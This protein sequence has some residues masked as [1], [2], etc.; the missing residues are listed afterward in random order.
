MGQKSEQDAMRQVSIKK[1]N[2]NGTILLRKVNKLVELRR[3]EKGVHNQSNQGVFCDWL[4]E[5]LDK[6]IPDLEKKVSVS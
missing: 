5:Q 3:V 4:L 2:R 6:Q 1:T